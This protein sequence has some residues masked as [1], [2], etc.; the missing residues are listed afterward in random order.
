MTTHT[1]GRQTTRRDVRERAMQVLYAYEISQ[2]PI[3]MLMET[4]AG[5]ELDSEP[6]LYTFAQQLVYSVLNHR[7][8]SDPVI[9]RLTANWDFE[10]IAVL[11]RI[12]L[13]MGFCEFMYFSDIPVKVTINEYVDI[14]KRYSTNKSSGFLNGMLDAVLQDLRGQGLVTKTGRGIIG[15]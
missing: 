10:R 11:D 3:E 9:K 8:E 1:H 5:I 15:A 2:E 13:R 6:E 7:H 14:A 4:I 12:L